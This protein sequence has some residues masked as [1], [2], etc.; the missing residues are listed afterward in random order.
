MQ[1]QHW[2]ALL[3][4]APITFAGRTIPLPPFGPGTGWVVSA[5]G[6]VCPRRRAVSQ[7][8]ALRCVQGFSRPSPPGTDVCLTAT[9]AISSTFSQS[10]VS[11]TRAPTCQSRVGEGGALGTVTSHLET[12]CSQE[13][14]HHS[15]VD[16][17]GVAAHV[18][19]CL[20]SW[21]SV[22]TTA[23]ATQRPGH[24]G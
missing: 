13:S 4:H 9:P 11:F 22:G 15:Q 12:F 17:E 21:G 6:A 23:G 14:T 19:V 18:G 2:A 3:W 7:E 1:A 16:G 8:H 24:M 20:Q 10:T 5:A